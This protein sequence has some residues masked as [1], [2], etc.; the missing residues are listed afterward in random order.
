[1]NKLWS[2]FHRNEQEIDLIQ[3]SAMFYNENEAARQLFS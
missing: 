1:M 2:C 3:G